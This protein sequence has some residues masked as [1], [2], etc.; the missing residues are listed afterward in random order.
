MVRSE[1]SAKELLTRMLSTVVREGT[2]M[3]NVGPKPDGTIPEQAAQ[4][5]RN[6]GNWIKK[7]P[8]TLYAAQASP[9]KHTLPWG[10]G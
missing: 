3:L 6:S 1:L 5:L 10:D 7:Y 4:A 8:Q 2:Y 9:W